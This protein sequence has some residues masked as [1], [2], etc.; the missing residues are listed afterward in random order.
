MRP[1]SHKKKNFAILLVILAS[2]LQIGAIIPEPFC[3]AIVRSE[4]VYTVAHLACY[5]VLAFCISLYL[6]FQRT[7][8]NLKI[9]D[10]S[11]LAMAFLL[12]ALFGGLTEISQ[13]LSFIDRRANWFDFRC[14]L[15]GAGGGAIFFLLFKYTFLRFAPKPLRATPFF[16][17]IALGKNA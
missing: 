16:Y 6:R 4:L 10:V 13:S 14:N 3:H 9:T 17:R 11:A 12:T 2:L 8:L 5:A 1:F 7:V 15:I